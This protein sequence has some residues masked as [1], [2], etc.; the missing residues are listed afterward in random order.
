MFPLIVNRQ[1]AIQVTT[2]DVVSRIKIIAI[3]MN[4]TD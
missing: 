3:E 4:C 1:N 2:G